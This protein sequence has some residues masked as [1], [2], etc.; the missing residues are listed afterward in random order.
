[1]SFATPGSP[2]GATELTLTLVSFLPLVVEGNT[3]G[4]V[5]VYDAMT[6]IG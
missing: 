1:M 5:L 2:S 4:K 3:V 6:L